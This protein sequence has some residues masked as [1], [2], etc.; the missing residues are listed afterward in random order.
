ML[1]IP[2]LQGGIFHGFLLRNHDTCAVLAGISSASLVRHL[3]SL[4]TLTKDII[5][6]MSRYHGRLRF[7]S[8]PIPTMQNSE[9][10]LSLGLARKLGMREASVI[11]PLGFIFARS[12]FYCA[13]AVTGTGV[14]CLH[15]VAGERGKGETETDRQS[16]QASK[17]FS[18]SQEC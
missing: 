17:S 18:Q 13:T 15:F 6:G 5:C 14:I 1:P 4:N 2:P 9:L 3:P 8:H 7:H 16:V 11:K 10:S 12:T